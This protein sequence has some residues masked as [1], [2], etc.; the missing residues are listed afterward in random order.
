M[1]QGRPGLFKGTS[2]TK[3]F[4]DAIG[5]RRQ[6]GVLVDTVAFTRR[7]PGPILRGLLQRRRQVIGEAIGGPGL[8]L[9]ECGSGGKPAT[10]LSDRCRCHT[11]VDFSATGLAEATMALRAA[12][13]SF[14]T[15]EA[16]ITNLPFNDG[17]YDVAYSAHAIYH[18]DTA[19][20]QAAALSEVMRVV[21]PG[22][23]AIFVLANPFPIAFPM[24]LVRRAAAMTPV[25]GPLLNRLRTKPPLP[26]LPMPLS[27]VQRQLARWG[28]VSMTCH[29]IPSVWFDQHV[30]ERSFIGRGL[31]QAIQLI[32]TTSPVTAARLGCFV[33][34]IVER[35]AASTT[36]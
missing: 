22:G 6:E 32:E 24:R 11:A 1:S 31:W 15:V 33:T 3:E 13:V 5:W 2:A 21:R 17:E 25:L 10:F 19:D 8:N 16:D 23:R 18:I 30:S 7:D 12:G 14:K 9:V 35:T 4:Y 27:W 20:G 28:T 36:V 29:A 26:Y 34:V